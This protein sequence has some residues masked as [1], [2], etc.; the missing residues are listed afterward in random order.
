MNNLNRRLQTTLQQRFGETLDL[1]PD[2]PGAGDLLR[3]AE[4]R[5]HRRWAT[6]PLPPELTRLLA[7][8]ALSAP[9]KSYLQQ[10][11]IIDVRD[12][13]QRAALAA[14]TPTMPWLADAPALLVFCGNGRR[15]KRLFDRKG[16][17]FTNDHLDSFFNCVVD[18]SMVMMN[19]INAAS[20]AGLVCCSI[21][22]LRNEAERLARILQL[23]Q[24]VVPVAGLC[25]GYPSFEASALAPL[26]P[27][28]PLRATFHV[29]RMGAADDDTAIDDFDARHVE[30]RAAS[31]GGAPNPRTWS[32]ERTHQYATPQREDWGRF[33]RS[34]G[35]NLK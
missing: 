14:L 31:P 15:F 35:F 7:A 22:M 11:D 2:L 6:T 3:I 30:A 12:A 20:A 33:V 5:S 26:Q 16:L 34:Q 29:D 25:I 13:G 18:A 32:A 4:H 17:P 27:R 10:V 19:F 28:L 9:T 24:R 1:P 23:P 21:S 8:C